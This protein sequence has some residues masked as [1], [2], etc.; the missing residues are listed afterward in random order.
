M[1]PNF[2]LISAACLIFTG[3]CVTLSG[4]ASDRATNERLKQQLAQQKEKVKKLEM[5]ITSLRGTVDTLRVAL[6]YTS[7]GTAAARQISKKYSIKEG[8]TVTRI[9]NRHGISR[10]T[11]MEVNSITENQQIYIGDE[12]IIPAPPMPPAPEEMVVE[13]AVE[14]PAPKKTLGKTTKPA[15]EKVSPIS[16]KPKTTSIA[17]FLY[18]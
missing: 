8:E 7:G 9:A 1:K 2:A 13:T 15:P 6:A 4:A 11:L 5:A 17:S 3:I 12:L 14:T 18:L 16:P 10:E